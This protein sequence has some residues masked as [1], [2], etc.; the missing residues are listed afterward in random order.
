MEKLRDMLS[1]D[2]SAPLLEHPLTQPEHP[3]ALSVSNITAPV[4]DK[5]GDNLYF[6]TF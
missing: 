6:V 5:V 1:G 3:L 2:S 4:I